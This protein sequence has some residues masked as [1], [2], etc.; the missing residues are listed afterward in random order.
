ML[1]A[2]SAA[3]PVYSLRYIM[4]CARPPRCWP[5]PR[6]RPG[7]AGGTLALALIVLVAL[8]G[9]ASDRGVGSHSENLRQLIHLVAVHRRPGD[10]L[11]F[12]R[13]SDREFEAAYPAPSAPSATSPSARP[14]PNPPPS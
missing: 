3:H 14:P 6:G 13:L 7:W 2:A 8:P 1:L 5:G 12:P 10:A 4:F 9:Q 11:L